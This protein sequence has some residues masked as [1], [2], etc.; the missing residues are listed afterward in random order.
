MSRK[1]VK[2]SDTESIKARTTE[3]QIE[4]GLS[5]FENEF[6]NMQ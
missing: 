6:T 4:A 2:V 5:N 3:S 1:S